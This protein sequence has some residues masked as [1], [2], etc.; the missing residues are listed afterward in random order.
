[1]ASTVKSR[2]LFDP[3]ILKQAIVDSFGK[4]TVRR[5]VR[6]PVMFVVYIGAI[7]TTMLWLQAI[8]G[9][10]EAPAWFIFWVSVAVVHRNLANF[11]EA[12]IGMRG[13]ARPLAPPDRARPKASCSRS[14]RGP[15]SA[16]VAAVA[17]GPVVLS[18][19]CDSFRSTAPSSIVASVTIARSPG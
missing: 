14:R 11:A 10:G 8:V 15:P 2:S 6:N 5:Q 19:P 9:Q 18:R 12:M 7:L 16:R 1:M 3:S 4:L 13:K 17:Q